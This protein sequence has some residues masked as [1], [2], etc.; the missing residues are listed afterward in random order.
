[1][2]FAVI[3]GRNASTD[4]SVLFGHNEQNFGLNIINYRRVPRLSHPDGVRLLGGGIV[5]DLTE[6]WSFFWSEAPGLEFSDNCFNEWGVAVAGNGCPTRED[7]VATLTA[8]GDIVDGGIGYMLPRLV[9]MR[10]RTAREGVEWAGELVA[11]FGY[12]GTGRSLIIADPHEA[13][14]MAIA[15]GKR[16]LVRRVPDDGVVVIPNAHVIGADTDLT[17][18]ENVIASPGLVDYAISRG[19]HTPGSEPFSFRAAFSAPGP[20]GTMQERYGVDSRQWRGQALITGTAAPLPPEGELPFAVRAPRRLGVADL[21]ALLRSHLEDTEFDYRSQNPV[22]SPHHPEE[23]IDNSYCRAICNI[24]TQ[25]SSIFQLRSELPP[26]IGC[27]AW[28]ATSVPCASVYTPWYLGCTELAAIYHQ[29]VPLARSLELEHHF[30]PAA[31]FG[32]DEPHVFWPFYRLVQRADRDWAGAGAAIRA[33]YAG[34]EAAQ[35]QLQPVIET[36]AEELADADPALLTAYLTDYSNGRALQALELA[37]GL[38]S[39]LSA[40]D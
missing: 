28:R 9:A 17:D 8:R 33:A 26:A 12:T 5:A 22:G 1:M 29:P 4:G 15:R 3:V 37:R 16:W 32:P 10:A 31:V 2:C 19:W 13:W 7:D 36:V 40:R 14:V 21:A 24:A 25:E 34:F 30:G 11:R 39:R 23:L 35:Y 6:S 18:G 38:E 20:A 27:V